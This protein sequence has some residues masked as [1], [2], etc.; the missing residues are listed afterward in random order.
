MITAVS[1]YSAHAARYASQTTEYGAVLNAGSFNQA[2][3]HLCEN[4]LEDVI[5]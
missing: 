2:I 4:Y 3:C 5:N 1:S